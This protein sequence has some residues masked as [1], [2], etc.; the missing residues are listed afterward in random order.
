MISLCILVPAC[1][2]SFRLVYSLLPGVSV[3]VSLALSFPALL[4]PL[5]TVYLSLPPRLRVPVSSSCVHRDRGPDLTVSG[6]HSP[7]FVLRFGK[8]LFCSCVCLSRGKEVATRPSAL[9]RVKSA[10]EFGGIAASGASPLAASPHACRSREIS[11]AG[12]GYP[13]PAGW[14]SSSRVA[15]PPSLPF[16]GVHA[17]VRGSPSPPFA[18]VHAAVRGS[19][20]PDSSPPDRR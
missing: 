15:A 14:V 2:V 6:A 11:A 19:P 8:F 3:H 20:R 4:S 12:C 5:K 13:K 10:W 18:G 7:R 17:A 1:S 16:A 9:A